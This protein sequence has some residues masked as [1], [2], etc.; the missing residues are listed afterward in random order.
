MRSWRWGPGHGVTIL[1]DA[2]VCDRRHLQGP[3]DRLARA[4]S[5]LSLHPR[6]VITTGEG[7]MIA[8]HDPELA[9][10]M[11]R[12]GPTPWMYPGPRAPT[13]R[14][15]S[16][17]RRTRSRGSSVRITTSRGDV[18][19]AN[20]EAL[21]LIL[22]RRRR[23]AERLQRANSDDSGARSPVRSALRLSDL[24]VVLCSRRRS[25]GPGPDGS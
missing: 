19:S 12:R 21:P 15:T 1:E 4:P 6:K 25:V 17:S 13:A 14:P 8:V 7:G 24:A 23:L 3:P 16:Y 9:R 10:R 2:G 22:A 11:R 20:S 5:V 18:G